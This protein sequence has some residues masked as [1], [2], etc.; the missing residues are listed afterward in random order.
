M[1][2]QILDAMVEAG[3]HHELTWSQIKRLADQ[4]PVE[5]GCPYCGGQ[6]ES[7]GLPSDRASRCAACGRLHLEG[8]VPL[9]Y[10]LSA[11]TVRDSEAEPHWPER[12]IEE[13]T[14][15]IKHDICTA[16]EAKPWLQWARSDKARCERQAEPEPVAPQPDP[17]REPARERILA[18]LA[19]HK[20][21]TA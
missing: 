16:E 7:K 13:L 3:L 9:D 12:I 10:E 8:A 14:Y 21:S 19:E 6:L 18:M 1:T 4:L 20:G 2:D 17:E 5:D 15:A 11:I